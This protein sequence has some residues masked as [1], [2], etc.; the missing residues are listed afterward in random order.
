M[1]YDIEESLFMEVLLMEMRGNDFLF[2]I[3]EK[4]EK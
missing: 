4:G 1:Q 3:R 2:F